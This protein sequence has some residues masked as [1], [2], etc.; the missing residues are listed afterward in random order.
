MQPGGP[1]SLPCGPMFHQLHARSCRVATKRP[2][3]TRLTSSH[4]MHAPIPR[5]GSWAT[6]LAW[7]ERLPR[8][9]VSLRP[10]PRERKL[11]PKSVKPH[12]AELRPNLAVGLIYLAVGRSRPQVLAHRNPGQRQDPSPNGHKRR[13]GASRCKDHAKNATQLWPNS[14]HFRPSPAG[15]HSARCWCIRR[16]CSRGNAN[17]APLFARKLNSS[18][19]QIHRA[20]GLGARHPTSP[21]TTPPGEAKGTR[22]PGARTQSGAGNRKSSAGHTSPRHVSPETSRGP[23]RCAACQKRLN[24]S[25]RNLPF[26]VDLSLESMILAEPWR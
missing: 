3:S 11:H 19:S 6:S 17:S 22:A 1:R 14:G 8:G 15:P 7:L 5:V 25:I 10:C 21:Q 18:T 24:Q 4:G 16:R 2:P 9:S 20:V 26:Q 12:F 23:C 13:R